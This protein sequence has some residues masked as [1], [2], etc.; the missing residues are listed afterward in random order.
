MATTSPATAQRRPAKA[1]ATLAAV[2][3]VSLLAGALPAEAAGLRFGAGIGAAIG[4][5][6][7]TQKFD[8]CADIG[9]RRLQEEQQNPDCPVGKFPQRQQQ[10]G[11]FPAPRQPGANAFGLQ[12]Y[13]QN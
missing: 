11:G 2:L 9:R 4:D 3:L 6:Q 7:Y 12:F 10:E 13:G 5:L 8:P 1:R